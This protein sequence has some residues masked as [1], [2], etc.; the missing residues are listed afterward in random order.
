VRVKGGGTGGIQFDGSEQFLQ[1]AALNR[2]FFIERV[3]NL[4]QTTPT[5]VPD[6]FAFFFDGSGAGFTFEVFKKFNG[7]KIVAAFLF[8]R[9]GPD[10][11]RFGD[12]VI[13]LV[14][15]RFRI[16]NGCPVADR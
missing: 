13:I 4:R 16:T 7:R 1:P 5:G 12:A 8:E 14:P 9:A 2:P 15:N 6:E 11:V 3:K 10:F